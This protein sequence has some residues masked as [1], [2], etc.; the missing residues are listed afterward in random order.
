MSLEP[1]LPIFLPL[2]NAKLFK[3][4]EEE[5]GALRRDEKSISVIFVCLT[6]VQTGEEGRQ[7]LGVLILGRR[8][9]RFE[10]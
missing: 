3:G 7:V 9:E 5:E 4:K 10:F 6:K 1:F 8:L 2:M